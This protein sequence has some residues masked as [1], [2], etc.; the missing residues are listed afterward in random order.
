MKLFFNKA[1]IE[2]H[3]T[4]FIMQSLRGMAFVKQGRTEEGRALL[5]QSYRGLQEKFGD[6][7]HFNR[8]AR[9]RKQAAQQL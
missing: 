8:E 2:G 6:D 4:F 9:E 1:L 7:H 5:D 3:E